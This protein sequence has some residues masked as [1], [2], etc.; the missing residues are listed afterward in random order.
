MKSAAPMGEQQWN[1]SD[2]AEEEIAGENGSDVN[3]K[4]D[5]SSKSKNNG[6]GKQGKGKK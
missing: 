3:A 6:S 5:A 1:D 4:S 2:Y